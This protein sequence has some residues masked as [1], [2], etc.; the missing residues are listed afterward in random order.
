MNTK[1]FI[2]K[3]KIIAIIR[4][5]EKEKI[6][7]TAKALYAGGIRLIEITFDQSCKSGID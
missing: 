4:G 6:V 3:Y 1:D 2:R 7:D 5:I